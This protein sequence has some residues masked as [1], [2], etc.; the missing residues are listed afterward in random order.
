MFQVDAERAAYRIAAIKLV[1]DII[2]RLDPDEIADVLH[3]AAGQKEAWAL[4]KHLEWRPEP[5]MADRM[6][7]EMTELLDTIA[8]FLGGTR[9]ETWKSQWLLD[10]REQGRSEHPAEAA[11]RAYYDKEIA[12]V[13]P[14]APVADG[15]R[16]FRSHPSQDPWVIELRHTLTL[17]AVDDRAD[18][19]TNWNPANWP[20][21]VPHE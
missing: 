19:T 12:R 20:Q 1:R 7:Q 4:E 9:T 13:W 2:D 16:Q 14:P 8:P 18:S 5:E 6:R 21:T 10:G 3:D 17:T 11:A 15:S